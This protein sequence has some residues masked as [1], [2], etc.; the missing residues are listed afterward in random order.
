MRIK[1]IF[2]ELCTICFACLLIAVGLNLFLADAKL[3]S[4]GLTGIALLIEYTTGIWF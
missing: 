3:V 2:F 1:I 4:G